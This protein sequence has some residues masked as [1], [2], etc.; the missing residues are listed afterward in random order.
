M[1]IYAGKEYVCRVSFYA[2]KAK[3]EF[4]DYIDSS[5]FTV[6]A[7]AVLLSA[8]VIVLIIILVKKKKIEE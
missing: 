8:G 7:V 1:I 5:A 4:V 3:T 6:A 2:D